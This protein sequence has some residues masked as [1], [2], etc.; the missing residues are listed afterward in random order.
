ML[1]LLNFNDE[2]ELSKEEILF[3]KLIDDNVKSRF[4]LLIGFNLSE[5]NEVDRRFF[6]CTFKCRVIMSFLQAAYVHFG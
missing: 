5:S 1:I 4:V 6:V 2:H 3:S